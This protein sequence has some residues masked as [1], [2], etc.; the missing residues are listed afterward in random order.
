MACASH[1]V[2]QFLFGFCN[3]GVL[4]LRLEALGPSQLAPHVGTRRCLYNQAV[5]IEKR[6]GP[7]AAR[8]LAARGNVRRVVEGKCPDFLRYLQANV[9]RQRKF[10]AAEPLPFSPLSLSRVSGDMESMSAALLTAA[11]RVSDPDRTQRLLS[12]CVGSSLCWTLAFTKLLRL[13]PLVWTDAY[14]QR[15]TDSLLLSWKR[16]EQVVNTSVLACTARS[17]R[18]CPLP[19][20]CLGCFRNHSTH[21]HAQPQGAE[22]VRKSIV[23]LALWMRLAAFSLP[24]KQQSL[25]L[26]AASLLMLL[27]SAE[28]LIWRVCSRWSCSWLGSFGVFAC[29]ASDLSWVSWAR[30]L[31]VACWNV[32]RCARTYR[33]ACVRVGHFLRETQVVVVA[34][35]AWGAFECRTESTRQTVTHPHHMEHAWKHIW[36]ATTH[37]TYATAH[38]SGSP[39][40]P[41]PTPSTPPPH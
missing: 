8:G 35:C 17:F 13:P 24:W 41:T 1:R 26:S 15:L 33:L 20:S 32:Q 4:S 14:E 27:A 22:R 39:W 16:G 5:T 38:E 19:P 10:A 28:A 18:G 31:R 7:I 25:S 11:C 40:K 30:Y 2:S 23:L 21:M 3:V 36:R 6:H 9:E 12:G 34:H 29:D 37:T